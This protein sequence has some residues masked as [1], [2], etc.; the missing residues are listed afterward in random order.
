[1]RVEIFLNV[2]GTKAGTKA[3]GGDMGGSERAGQDKIKLPDPGLT[4]R[5]LAELAG[6]A[7]L[8]AVT[9]T[10][11]KFRAEAQS[12][13]ESVIANSK[14]ARYGL[15]T[16]EGIAYTAPGIINAVHHNLTN[17]PEMGFKVATAATIGLGLRLLLPEKGAARALVGT[18]MGYFFV[19]DALRPFIEAYGDVQRHAECAQ[20]RSKDGRWSGPFCSRLLCRY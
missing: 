17:L 9:S 4:E 15:V 3:G 16:V 18:T 6:N 2:Q 12:I 19:R 14:L 5:M 1:L 7:P 11:D 20:S 10:S 8:D 13:A